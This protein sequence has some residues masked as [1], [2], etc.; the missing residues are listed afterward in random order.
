MRKQFIVLAFVFSLAGCAFL[1]NQKANFDACKSDPVCWDK[2][3]HDADIAGS[4]V[5]SV[6]GLAPIPASGAV[7]KTAGKIVNYG[8]LGIAALIGGA[9]L[10]KKKKVEPAPQS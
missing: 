2:A 5:E 8:W 9:T 7:A 6:G 1:Q 3:K 4:I 10:R